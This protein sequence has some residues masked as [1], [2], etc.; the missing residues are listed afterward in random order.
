MI[1][2]IITML[3]VS[4]YVTGCN[5]LQNTIKKK[6]SSEKVVVITDATFESEVL[7]S[8]IPVLVDFWA[9]WWPN[10]KI[11]API[12]D[13]LAEEYD[14]KVK[15][16]KLNIDDNTQISSLYLIRSNPT[17][18]IFKDGELVDEIF[19]ATSKETIK[20]KIKKYI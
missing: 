11:I 9:D 12:I 3:V 1:N 15:I 2:Q 16:G 20:G 7:Q 4:Y 18:L 14:G 17:L 19:G 10:S 13:E 6:K 5:Q 8:N